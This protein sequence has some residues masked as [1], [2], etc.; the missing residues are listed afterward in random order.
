MASA[1]VEELRPLEESFDSHEEAELHV[2]SSSRSL[3]SAAPA[4]LAALLLV[5]LAAAAS[6]RHAGSPLTLQT[7]SEFMQKSIGPTNE[8]DVLPFHKWLIAWHVTPGKLTDEIYK[9]YSQHP[10][11]LKD[12]AALTNLVRWQ[13]AHDCPKQELSTEMQTQASFL[14]IDNVQ[15]AADC[16]K[17]CTENSGNCGAWTWGAAEG[18]TGLSHRCFMKRLQWGEQP[19]RSTNHQVISGLPCNPDAHGIWWAD[20]K[21][22]LFQ[23]PSPAAPKVAPTP[24]PVPC[25][26]GDES[27]CVNEG[28]CAPVRFADNATCKS[29]FKPARVSGTCQGNG[30]KTYNDGKFLC[31]PHPSNPKPSHTSL[32]CVALFLAYSSEQELLVNS[33]NRKAS[34]F[35]CD[36]HAVY[37]SQVLELTPG[38]VSR[39]ISSSMKA[40]VGGQWVTVLNL[41]IFLALYRQL[42]IDGD[43][44]NFDWTVKVDPD[45]VWFPQRLRSSLVKYS[46]G[47]GGDGI[48]LNNCP[49][50][51]HGPIEVFSKAAF[52]ALGLKTST[53]NAKL[54]GPRCIEH[55]EGVWNQLEICNGDCIDWWGEDLWVDQC[56]MRFSDARRALAKDLLQEAH[57]HPPGWM[58]TDWESCKYK[59]IVAFHPFKDVGGF[60]KCLDNA[61]ADEH[62][63]SVRE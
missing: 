39:R 1:E 10:Q 52:R 56:L 5:S 36:H 8:S 40:E 57:C 62:N 58:K 23:L 19:Q 63:A 25:H 21:S 59:E 41:G 30:A 14:T 44:L 4:A 15:A 50:G 13:I 53:C 42:I 24:P 34:L 61:L 18:V 33:F 47:V 51:L 38:L 26:N 12:D 6:L 11:F 37:S 49:D 9:A 43:Y 20:N 22:Q 35:Q 17:A 27:K 46:W 45:T 55:C 28:C 7:G 2:T 29:G 32:F 48:Y 60:N 54:N 16:Q 31:C 3:R